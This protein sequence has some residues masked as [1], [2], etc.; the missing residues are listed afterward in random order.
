LT[1]LSVGGEYILSFMLQNTADVPS[2]IQVDFGT[3]TVF[4]ANNP[5]ASGPAGTYAA[6]H[7]NLFATAAT[8][9]LKFS[10]TDDPSFFF[11]DNVSVTV[12]EPATLALVVAALAGLGYTR[13]QRQA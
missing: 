4:A 1:G 13:R 3:T 7:F 2:S 6:Y 5:V 8:Q 9:T 10:F 11:L 12:P